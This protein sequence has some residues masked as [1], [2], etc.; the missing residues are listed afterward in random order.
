MHHINIS[1]VQSILFAR[2][3]PLIF[4]GNRDDNIV[5]HT[6]NQSPSTANDRRQSHLHVLT[7]K[8]PVLGN[9]VI[10]IPMH[11]ARG[12]KEQVLVSGR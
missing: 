1:L 7:K 12:C 5:A 6:L 2:G 8:V 11:R 4:W 3:L 9:I 10:F